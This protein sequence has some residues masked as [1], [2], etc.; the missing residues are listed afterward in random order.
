MSRARP[1]DAALA[2]A[3]TLC[4]SL[5]LTTLFTPGSWFRPSVLLVVLVALAG[6]GLRTLTSSRF[7]VVFGQL[8]L[9]ANGTAILHGQG[10]LWHGVVPTPQTGRA[11]GVL[12]EQAYRTVT[13][14]TA[15]APSN[16]GTMLAISLLLGLTAVAVDAAA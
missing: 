10:H 2:A 1:A 12:L 11:F 15:P 13:D 4:V 3:A 8:V 16:R 9:L 7:I 14:Y 6:V 5:P